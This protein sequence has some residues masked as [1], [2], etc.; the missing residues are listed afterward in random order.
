M[1]PIKFDEQH[2][3][4]GTK[5]VVADQNYYYDADG[6]VTTDESKGE[7]WLAREGAAVLPEHKVAL[8]EFQASTGEG[9]SAKAASDEEPGEKASSPASNKAATPKKN[10]GAK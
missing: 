2:P 7:R 9:K 6:N 3:G 1:P 4:D 10:K 8:A 5:E